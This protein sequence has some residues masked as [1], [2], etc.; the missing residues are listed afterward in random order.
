MYIKLSKI[1]I[2]LFEE[3]KNFTEHIEYSNDEL[4]EDFMDEFEIQ[5]EERNSDSEIR[6]DYEEGYDEDDSEEPVF[7][8]DE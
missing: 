5:P 2:L 8:L 6:I 4:Q 7:N 1:G 3:L